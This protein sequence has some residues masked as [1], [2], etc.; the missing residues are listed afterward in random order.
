M[1]EKMSPESLEAMRKVM[2]RA[3]DILGKD[4]DGYWDETWAHLG[5]LLTKMAVAEEE[6]GEGCPGLTLYIADAL[7]LASPDDEPDEQVLLEAATLLRKTANNEVELKDEEVFF[8]KLLD[9]NWNIIA[10][11]DANKYK[12]FLEKMQENKNA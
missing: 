2:I 1:D 8:K 10:D 7:R 3:L 6:L 9:G 12:E 4:V 11:F 5:K